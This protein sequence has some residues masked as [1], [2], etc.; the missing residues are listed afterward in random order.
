MRGNARA[1]L[2]YKPTLG[3]YPPHPLQVLFTANFLGLLCAVKRLRT[4]VLTK[5]A[6]KL[7]RELYKSLTWTVLVLSGG[8]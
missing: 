7:P 1:A 6:Q 4:A 2:L 5:S 8:R 3:Q